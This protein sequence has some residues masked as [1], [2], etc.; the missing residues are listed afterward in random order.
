MELKENIY[1]KSFSDV[2]DTKSLIMNHEI[3]KEVSKY[4]ILLV[5]NFFIFYNFTQGNKAKIK[6]CAIRAEAGAVQCRSE[7]S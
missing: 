6:I 1:I 4:Y 5:L 3:S 2:F 7:Q